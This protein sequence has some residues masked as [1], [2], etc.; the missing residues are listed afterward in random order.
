MESGAKSSKITKQMSWLVVCEE[1]TRKKAMDQFIYTGDYS[2][3]RSHPPSREM[4]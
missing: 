1:L 3:S 4:P 2:A